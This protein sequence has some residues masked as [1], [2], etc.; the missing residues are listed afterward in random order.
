MY[1]DFEFQEGIYR[2]VPFNFIETN[3][4]GGRKSIFHIYPNSDIV[5]SE[6]LGLAP[7]TISIKI[8]IHGSA[9]EEKDIINAS[10]TGE[11]ANSLLST[12]GQR[13]ESRRDT[14]IKA[15]ETPG[16]ALM[17]H[18]TYGLMYVQID[19]LYSTT[20]RISEMGST[21]IDVAF[22]IVPEP[23]EDPIV[24]E[25][26]QTFTTAVSF[27]QSSDDDPS[28]IDQLKDELTEMWEGSFMENLVTNIKEGYEDL[29]EGVEELQKNLDQVRS[30]VFDTIDDFN[31]F[32]TEVSNMVNYFPNLI[33]SMGTVI[34]RELDLIYNTVTT[35]AYQFQ[36]FTNMF[37][38]LEGSTA[39]GTSAPVDYSLTTKANIEAQNSENFTKSFVQ[40]TALAYATSSA[41]QID[42]E[43]DVELLEAKAIIEAQFEKVMTYPFINAE[44]DAINISTVGVLNEDFE[45]ADPLDL[46]NTLQKQ[47]VAFVRTMEKKLLTVPKVTDVTIKENSLIEFIYKY[48]GSLDLYDTIRDLNQIDDSTSFLS[49]TYKILTG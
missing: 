23:K 41:S 7:V 12:I 47:K 17:T 33:S 42:F 16:V 10:Y 35:P 38:F 13:Y 21:E 3:K 6:D 34:V 1:T 29:K 40:G 28:Y 44:L 39:L 49:G 8:F 43:T 32:A 30:A 20:E 36:A 37:D 19:G 5:N 18:P 31:E 27:L 45:T 11:R 4:T 24:I 48:Y 14:M 9:M 15:L 26:F 22:K 46:Y 25:G 2:G